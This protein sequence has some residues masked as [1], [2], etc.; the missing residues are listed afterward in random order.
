MLVQD[1]ATSPRVVV[2]TLDRLPRP[3]QNLY[4]S[5]DDVRGPK[6][7]PALSPAR[8]THARAGFLIRPCQTQLPGAAPEILI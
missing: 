7:K 8:L 1:T 6:R 5:G 3:A 4:C 2:L